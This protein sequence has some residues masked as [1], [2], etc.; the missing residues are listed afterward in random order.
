MPVVTVSNKSRA[1]IQKMEQA[2]ADLERSVEEIIA[3]GKPWT[4]PDF[5]PEVKSLYDP[6][7]DQV[8]ESVYKAF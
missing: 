2:Q 8:D 7:I 5:P 4:D 1:A 3:K 6:N